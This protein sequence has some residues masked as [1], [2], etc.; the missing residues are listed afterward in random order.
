MSED[1]IYL[2]FQEDLSVLVSPWSLFLL[3]LIKKKLIETIF[4][5]IRLK[6]FSSYDEGSYSCDRSPKAIKCILDKLIG[7]KGLSRL[8]GQ[9]I[10]H[11]QVALLF[12]NV[13]WP[14]NSSSQI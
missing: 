2:I 10:S 12:Q 1:F 8:N 13:A 14:S 3:V 7:T 5:P 6:F 9:N 11:F 4:V